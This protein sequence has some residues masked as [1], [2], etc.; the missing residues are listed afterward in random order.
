L[1][2]QLADLDPSPHHPKM[3]AIN[4]IPTAIG[5]WLDHGS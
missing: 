3:T 1:V 5:R 2:F 4:L